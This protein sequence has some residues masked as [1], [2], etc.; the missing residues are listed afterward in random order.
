MHA[1]RTD[2]TEVRD[3]FLLK[4]DDSRASFDSLI[5]H[6]K[7][8]IFKVQKLYDI[9]HDRKTPVLILQ[10]RERMTLTA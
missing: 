9:I 6:F 10:G 8:V 3:C 5:E 2:G 7:T 4:S 1:M